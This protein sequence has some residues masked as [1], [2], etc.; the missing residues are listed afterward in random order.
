VTPS[1]GAMEE[2]MSERKEGDDVVGKEKTEE[3]RAGGEEIVF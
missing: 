2:V 3:I 1:E